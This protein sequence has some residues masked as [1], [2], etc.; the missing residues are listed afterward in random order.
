MPSGIAFDFDHTLGIDN[1]LE[2]IAFLRLLE[3]VEA[4]GGRPGAGDFADEQRR[5]DDLLAFQRAGGA[6]IGDAVRGFVRDHGVAPSDD[7]VAY[8][9][10]LCLG[11]VD[12]VVVPLPG[13]GATL[14]ALRRR[15]I[16]VAILTNG[17]NP[18]QERK[19]ARIGFDGPVIASAEIGVQKPARAAFAAAAEALGVPPAGLWFV[20]DDPV[21]DIAGALDAGVGA[22]IWLDAEGRSYPAGVTA[23]T[24][25]IEALPDLL[26]LIP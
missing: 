15:E 21:A 18:L 22:A 2:R 20:G 23:P 11:L 16:P 9:E 25:R 3:R 4:E 24:H 8:Y 26:A 10:G 1:K 17:W 5:I 6:T 13:A 7:H 12:Q 14:A 19:A